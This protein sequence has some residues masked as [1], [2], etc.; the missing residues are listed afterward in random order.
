M[1]L[2]S[3]TVGASLLALIAT[4]CIGDLGD[5]RNAFLTLTE[6]F[7]VLASDEP[8]D[9]GAAGGTL[10]VGEFRRTMTATFGNHCRFTELDTSFAAWVNTS[11]IRS[12]EQQ[13][14]LLDAGYVQLTRELRIGTAFTLPPGTFVLNGPGFA[15]GTPVRLGVAGGDEDAPVPAT[16][17]YDILTPDVFLVFSQPPVS[18]DSVAFA[19]LNLDQG[20]VRTGPVTEEAGG[21]KT[22][23]Q[24]DVYQCEPLRP[25][26]FL[27]L[28]GGARE[29]NEFFEGENIEFD[30]YPTPD[31]QGNFAI[32]TITQ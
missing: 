12:A 5:G 30:F 19:Y 11:S 18:C 8:A 25:G 3:A 4:G 26:L 2:R 15:G 16:I 1:V 10:A 31:A 6:I 13:D 21:A 28:G 29:A 32:V 17:S 9:S 7:G 27:K 22:F 23:A 14:V 20:T 24:V